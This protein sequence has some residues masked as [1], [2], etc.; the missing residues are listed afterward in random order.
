MEAAALQMQTGASAL[1]A[2]LSLI[3]QIAAPQMS[4]DTDETGDAIVSHDFVPLDL[5]ERRWAKYAEYVYVT[6]KRP[7]KSYVIFRRAVIPTNAW[8]SMFSI[9]SNKDFHYKYSQQTADIADLLELT[10]PDQTEFSRFPFLA[11]IQEEE[12]A[13]LQRKILEQF[14]ELPELAADLDYI[15]PSESAKACARE[16]VLRL[17]KM[18][19]M[20]Y[21]IS[22][23]ELG[24][25]TIGASRGKKHCLLILCQPDGKVW[26][27]M[28]RQGVKS[29]RHYDSLDGLPDKYFVE[30]L[31]ELE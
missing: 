6:G 12:F 11:Q 21:S 24:W 19:P 20:N 18:Y 14:D 17:L 7:G 16:L 1:D 26:C 27:F 15:E 4:S 29:Y 31:A 23:D 13:G 3:P 10:A 8:Q 9:S 22:P 2:A 25:V 5:A 28:S 30:A